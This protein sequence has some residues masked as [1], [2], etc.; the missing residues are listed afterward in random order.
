VLLELTIQYP[1]L[2]LGPLTATD[3]GTGVKALQTKSGNIW[4][5]TL[6][7]YALFLNQVCP[8]INVYGWGYQS[9]SMGNMPGY[10]CAVDWNP[11]GNW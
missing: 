10:A 7:A 11:L 8:P 3:Y 6:H 4:R 5:D 2:Q 1:D 9:A